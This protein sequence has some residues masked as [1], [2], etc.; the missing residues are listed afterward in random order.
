[1]TREMGNW[2]EEE[3]WYVVTVGKRPPAVIDLMDH[4]DGVWDPSLLVRVHA[5][6]PAEAVALVCEAVEVADTEEI[7]VRA[8]RISDE[9]ARKR[10]KHGAPTLK[11]YLTDLRVAERRRQSV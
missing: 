1:M 7:R 6:N 5:A 4:F 8:Y 10:G 11:R 9:S 3:G 2:F